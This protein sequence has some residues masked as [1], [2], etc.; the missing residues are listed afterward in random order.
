MIVLLVL[1]MSILYLDFKYGGDDGD[2]CP[3]CGL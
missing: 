3:G 2:G 1:L